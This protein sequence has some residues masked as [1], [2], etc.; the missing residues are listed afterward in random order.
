MIYAT[1]GNTV[2]SFETKNMQFGLNF[3]TN[4]NLAYVTYDRR[5]WQK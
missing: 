2:F 4:T 3:D 1:L 5:Y